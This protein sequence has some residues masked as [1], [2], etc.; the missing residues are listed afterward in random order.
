MELMSEKDKKD[1]GINPII[2]KMFNCLGFL[3]IVGCKADSTTL[4]V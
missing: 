1:P 4:K 3:V 2:W